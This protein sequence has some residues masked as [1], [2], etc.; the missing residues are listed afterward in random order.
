[1]IVLDQSLLNSLLILVGVFL[2]LDCLG[3]LIL[4][5]QISLYI[6]EVL[7]SKQFNKKMNNIPVFFQYYT[8]KNGKLIENINLDNVSHKTL[9]INK[10]KL[11]NR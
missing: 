4:M 7:L 9:S 6:K 5:W 8:L 11:R 10:S 2:L 1:M 3:F